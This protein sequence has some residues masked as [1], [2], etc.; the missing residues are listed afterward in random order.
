MLA[1]KQKV[2]SLIP[3]KPP[4]A[5]VDGLMESDNEKTISA[6]TVSEDNLFVENN[7]FKEPGLIENIAQTAALRSGYE[8]ERK[9]M[10][11]P[12]GFI[13]SVKKM[14]IYNLPE[15]GQTLNTK[16]TVLL[17]MENISV[18]KGEVS[19]NGKLI[20]EGEMNIFL[21]QKP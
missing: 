4:M 8:A 3:Q 10:K 16:L 7:L 13:G 11:P 12:V 14:K 19:V 21:Q 6:L 17:E 1:E 15:A 18:V 2:L 5:M 20:A 9:G